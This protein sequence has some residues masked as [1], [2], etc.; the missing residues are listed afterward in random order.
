MIY[1]PRSERPGI[2]LRKKG[3]IIRILISIMIIE[4]SKREEMMI[5][6]QETVAIWEWVPMLKKWV[7]HR[8][9]YHP[10]VAAE[11]LRWL[12]EN[13]QEWKKKEGYVY[14][15]FADGFDPNE[16]IE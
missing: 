12:N 10:D 5:M 8:S 7:I 14:E 16:S 11:A 13:R 15:V 1:S 2:F 6:Q 4:E 3:V 9:G